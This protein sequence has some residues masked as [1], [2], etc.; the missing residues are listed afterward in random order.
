VFWLGSW[1]ALFAFWLLLVDTV[2]V[3]ELCAGAVA[4]ALGASFMAAVRRQGIVSFRPRVRWLLASVTVVPRAV[5]D[6]GVLVSVLARRVVL[7]RDVRGGFRAVPF[8]HRGVGGDATARRV[9]T[10]LVAS[11]APNTIVLDVDEDRDL[12]LVHQL[13]PRAG[14]RDADPLGLG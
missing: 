12:V 11:F 10:K 13:V 5:A 3:P 6:L 14:R 2:K 1:G 8:R 4:A 9:L 7:R